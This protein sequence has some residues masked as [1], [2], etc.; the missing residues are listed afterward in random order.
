MDDT[1][2][3]MKRNY[4][5]TPSIIELHHL[6]IY[7]QKSLDRWQAIPE[8]PLTYLSL[9]NT[10]PTSDSI[11]LF[12]M[13]LYGYDMGQE[14]RNMSEDGRKIKDLLKRKQEQAHMAIDFST[15]L[16]ARSI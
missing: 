4:D 10:N 5:F 1:V 2:R 11:Q 6:K 13:D 7:S 16:E 15:N 9:D 8:S 12:F 14:I 3:I